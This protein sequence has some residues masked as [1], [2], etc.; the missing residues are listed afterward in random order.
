MCKMV[1]SVD[2]ICIS[3]MA[4]DAVVFREYLLVTLDSPIDDSLFCT[5][6]HFLIVYF[7]VMVT[8]FLNLSC[9][10]EISLFLNVGLLKIFSNSLYC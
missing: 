10:L 6:L 3:L 7:G 4:K 9:I 5:V 8:I 1:F 2:L